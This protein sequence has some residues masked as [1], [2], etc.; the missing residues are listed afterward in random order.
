MRDEQTQETQQIKTLD[1]QNLNSAGCAPGIQ[2]LLAT[3][4]ELQS[5]RRHLQYFTKEVKLWTSPQRKL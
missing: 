3:L 4:E 1:T 5:A 2:I